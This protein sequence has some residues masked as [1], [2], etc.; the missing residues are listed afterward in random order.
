MKTFNKVMIKPIKN[1]ILK[2]EIRYLP[3]NPIFR[4]LLFVFLPYLEFEHGFIAV[5]TIGANGANGFF[6]RYLVA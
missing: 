5:V 3:G 1:M 6:Y 2:I 4:I